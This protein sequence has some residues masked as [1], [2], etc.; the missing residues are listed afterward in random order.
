MTKISKQE[1]LLVLCQAPLFVIIFDPGYDISF[2]L[3]NAKC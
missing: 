3:C 2:D 1:E